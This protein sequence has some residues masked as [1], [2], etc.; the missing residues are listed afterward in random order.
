MHAY[1]KSL[2][3]NI[4]CAAN[5]TFGRRE[6]EEN[7]AGRGLSLFYLE[8]EADTNV[9]AV[10]VVAEEDDDGDEANDEDGAMDVLESADIEED[11]DDT[12]LTACDLD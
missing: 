4:M 8:D 5:N 3:Y 11:D 6:E 7:P 9:A 12:K 1:V 2:L 10:V